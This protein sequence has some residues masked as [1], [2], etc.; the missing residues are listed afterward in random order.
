MLNLDQFLRSKLY[1]VGFVLFCS[2]QT[3]STDGATAA[4]SFSIAGQ[5]YFVVANAGYEGKREVQSL[6]Y[7]LDADGSVEMVRNDFP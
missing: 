7:R 5:T 1:K 2:L 3:L 4:D 6:V